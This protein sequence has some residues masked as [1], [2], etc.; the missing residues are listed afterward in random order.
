MGSSRPQTPAVRIDTSEEVEQFD[1]IVIGAGVTGLYALYRLR[2]LGFSVRVF[3]DGGGVGGT[4]YW[5]RYPGARFDSESYTYGYSFSEDLLQEWDWK[6]HYSG[7]PE[8]E[9]YLNYVAD[10]FDLRRDIRLNSRVT[11]VVYDE[12]ENRWEIQTEDGH[13]ARAQFVIAAVGVLSAHYVPDFAGLESFQGDWC[14]TARWP[15][16]GMDLAGKRVGVIGTG[17]TAVQLIP[18]IA[19]EVAHLTVFQRTANYCVPLRNG[20]IDPEWQREIKASYPDI[21]KKCSETPGAFMHAFDPRSALALSPEERLAQYERLWAEPGFKKWLANFYDIMMPGEANEDYAEFVR[22]K[23]RERVK[24]PVVAEKL[25]PKDHPFGSKRLPCES[26]YYEV[27]NRDNVLLVDVR[28]APIE[29]IT[30]RGIQT[31]D[32]EYELDV[33]IFATGYDAVTGS[34]T[35]IDI[36]GEGGQTLK[37][38][39][40]EG[41]RTYMGIQSA[42]FPNLFTMPGAGAGNF[43]RGCEPLVEWVSDC[44]GYMRENEFTRISATPE[45]EEAWVQH[46]AEVGANLLRTKAAS[47]F[48]GANIPGKARV[49]L[50]S[51]ETAPVMRTKRAEVAANGYEGFLLQ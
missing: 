36:R 35:R 18:E 10:K 13:R 27:Y 26:G 23:I 43:T 1:V 7:Q 30:P 6:E 4:W 21:F 17:A 32:A 11:S 42:G 34:L 12:G 24:D 19:K 49:L 5:N 20:P 38:K 15:K 28:E 48:V 9:R 2:E 50:G 46:V 3:E 44:I 25:V 31:R 29:R 22:T 14:H 39:F 47:W 8:N 41:P 45:A 16:E 33:I 37:D 40:A 51:P